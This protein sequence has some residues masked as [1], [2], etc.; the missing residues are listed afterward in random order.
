MVNVGQRGHHGAEV[1]KSGSHVHRAAIA[2][3]ILLQPPTS[4]G[5]RARL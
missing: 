5:T 1:G 3:P 4:Y 2:A